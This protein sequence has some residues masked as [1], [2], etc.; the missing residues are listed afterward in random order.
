MEAENM[1]H[2]RN[3]YVIQAQLFQRECGDSSKQ[4]TTQITLQ[5]CKDQIKKLE[6]Q[7]MLNEDKIKK[8]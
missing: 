2:T 5:F 8:L 1:H 6:K 4:R 3:C 7:L